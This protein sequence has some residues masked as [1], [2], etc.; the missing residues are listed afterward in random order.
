ME[1]NLQKSRKFSTA[2]D[3]H[4]TV[5]N[6]EKGYSVESLK[7]AIVEAQA[8]ESSVR[9]VA[10]KHGIPSSTLHD[11]NYVHNTSKQIGA[12]GPTVLQI[13]REIA[14]ACVLLAEMGFGIT[15]ELVERDLFDYIRDNDIP[16]HFNG[17][18]PK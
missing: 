7:T 14:V 2:N 4:Y 8:D 16:N 6:H 5:A 15:R 17:G 13:R 11:H 18:V 3:L 9:A 1:A 10:K 12:G